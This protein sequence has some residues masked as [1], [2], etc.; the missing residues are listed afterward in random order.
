M[1]SKTKTSGLYEDNYFKSGHRLLKIKEGLITLLGWSFV[2]GLMTL[3]LISSMANIDTKI[4]QL[5]PHTSGFYEIN[6]MAFILISLSII[7][8]LI[9][10]FLT[11][12]NNYRNKNYYNSINVLNKR[13]EKRREQLFETFVT[14]RFGTSEFRHHVR[15][16]NVRPDQCLELN[17]YQKLYDEHHLNDVD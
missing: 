15:T 2:M 10:I 11:I 13:R 3:V 9:S 17:T 6:H 7:S 16:Y 5:L 8:F 12:M 4:P 14:D 1:Q